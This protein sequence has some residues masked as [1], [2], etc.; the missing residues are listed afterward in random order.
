MP[1]AVVFDL[2]GVLMDSEQRWNAAKEELV[3]E[4]GGRWRDDAPVTMMG[5]S[6]T[7]WAAYLRDELGVPMDAEAISADVVARME[8]G[9]RQELPLLPGA[10]RAVRELAARWP[11]GLA[12][13]SNR[14]I[15]DLVLDVA[16]FAGDFAVAISSEE[17]A[18]G[19]PAPDVYLQA[20]RRLGVDPARCVAI[21]DSSNG[22]RAAH[23]AGMA[24][25]AVPNPHYPPEPEALALAAARVA[26]VGDVTPEL[27]TRVGSPPDPDRRARG[28][29]RSSGPPP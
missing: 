13:S 10:R 12:S 24:V 5:M 9:Y 1:D 22:L 15:I 17:V 11:L 4:R 21:E 8:R 26:V 28:E 3:R 27:V 16:G 19:K 20:A 14:E 18:R 29:R 7:E 23:A 25:I 6:S 2:D